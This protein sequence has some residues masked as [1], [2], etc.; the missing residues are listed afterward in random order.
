M[1]AQSVNAGLS[2]SGWTERG[3]VFSIPPMVEG[4]VG[5]RFGFYLNLMHARRY[6]G[7]RVVLVG[8]AAHTV[9]PMAGQGL[10]LGIT[11]AE[12][13]TNYLHQTIKSGMGL[14]T[15][16]GLQYALQQYESERQRE[17]LA[18]MG[19]IQA[20]HGVFS[21]DF[22]PA[23]YMRSLGM[24][25]VNSVGPVRNYLASVAVGASQIFK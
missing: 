23:V 24:N 7:D 1:L 25:V 9:H 11:D 10:N 6:V 8:D 3:M 4:V 18:T 14:H 5:K 22:A 12:C 16:S 17:V 2:M 20:L 15:K 19:G 21:T 13:L